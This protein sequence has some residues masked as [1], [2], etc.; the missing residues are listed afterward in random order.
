MNSSLMNSDNNGN[1]FDLDRYLRIVSRFSLKIPYCREKEKYPPNL[2]DIKFPV[3]LKKWMLYT[4]IRNSQTSKLL[5][6]SS[7]GILD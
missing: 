6:T 1:K 4:T 7:S 3:A 5:F 2:C